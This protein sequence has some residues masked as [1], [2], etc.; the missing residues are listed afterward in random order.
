MKRTIKLAL[1]AAV[2]LTSTA[3]FA[4]NGDNLIAL[5]AKSLSMGGASTAHYNGAESATSNPALITKGKGTQFT[6]GGTYF[7][8]DVTVSKANAALGAPPAPVVSATYESDAKHNVIPFVALTENL[9]NGVSV[10]LSM[11]GSAGMGTD[12]RTTGA[13]SF[14]T[15]DAGLYSMSSSLMLMKFSVPVA[16][17]QDDWSV[18][19]APVVMYGA[20]GM[21][22]RTND[23]TN[24]T[25][26]VGRGTSGDLGL[27]Y[28]AGAA[29]TL[30]DMGLTAA[31]RYQSAIMMEY[32]N[33]ISVAADAFGYGNPLGNGNFGRFSDK[34]EQ[35]A[36]IG[37]G[38][39][40]TMGDISLTADFKQIKWGTAAGYKDFG[41]ENQNVYAIGAEYRMDKLALRAGYN[42]GKNPIKN[43]TD[44]RSVYGGANTNG[45]TMNALNHVMFP[46][47][48]EK[49]YTIGAGYQF[50]KNV[51]ADLALMYATSPDVTVNASSVG[52]GTLTVTNDQKAVAA[53]LNYAF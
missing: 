28:E 5:G 26:D 35:P 4:T 9:N 37:V 2:A 32:K 49:H 50:T 51:G 19:V 52:L 15:G 17:G 39:D 31:V 12:W 10:G 45:D 8:P 42:Y 46:A 24:P 47:V 11:Y 40:W 1:A 22:F 7:T 53:N 48:T 29:Y 44:S 27:G 30:K 14:G 6:F 16:Y 43:N 13:E 20:L 36:E 38:L 18:G 41:W 33:Q 25:Y 23:G 34:L 3:A 21:A